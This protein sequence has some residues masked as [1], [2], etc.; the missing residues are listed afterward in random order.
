MLGEVLAIATKSRISFVFIF[1]WF[2]IN[3][4]SIPKATAIFFRL[5]SSFFPCCMCACKNV[6]YDKCC[7]GIYLNSAATQIK[8]PSS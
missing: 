4:A 8:L 6:K 2:I 7:C 3:T 5:F 1:G